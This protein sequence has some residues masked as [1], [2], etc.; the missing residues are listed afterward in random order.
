MSACSMTTQEHV[1]TEWNCMAGEWDDNPQ[2]HAYSNH[3]FKIL[4]DMTNDNNDLDLDLSSSSSSALSA[5]SASSANNNIITIVD[6][7]CGTGLLTEKLVKKFPNANIICLDAASAMID[8]VQQ[9]IQAQEWKNVEAHCAILARYDSM[10]S[11]IKGKIT[12]L[13]G[14]VDLVV[15]SSV[16]AFVPKTDL[17]VTMKVIGDLLKPGGLFV[18]SD[19]PPTEEDPN[20]FTDEK[21]VEMY[22]M[23]E[24][25]KKSTS[26]HYISMNNLDILNMD[27]TSRSTS[28]EVFVGVAT[29]NPGD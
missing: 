8:L 3:F 22:A 29:K 4:C 7:G 13:N 28:V 17:C 24:L 5:S 6:F 15:A 19:W 21:A 12:E 11:E 25:R 16:M 9:K 14:R 1:N 10:K 18:H 2:V 27:S 20:G 26:I 23:G